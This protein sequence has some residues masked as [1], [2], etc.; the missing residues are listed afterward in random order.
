MKVQAIISLDSSDPVSLQQMDSAFGLAGGA[1]LP[2]PLQRAFGRI[3]GNAFTAR[4]VADIRD[5]LEH[6]LAAPVP[7]IFLD[8]HLQSVFAGGVVANRQLA[9][10]LASSF[11]GSLLDALQAA[12]EPPQ[13]L[14]RRHPNGSP[15]AEARRHP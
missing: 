7:T 5:H 1:D 9:L 10:R 4:D 8:S 12:A 6:R 11:L 2:E 13:S 3:R 14:P 15:D